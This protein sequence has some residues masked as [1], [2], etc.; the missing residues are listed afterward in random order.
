[1]NCIGAFAMLKQHKAR[2]DQAGIYKVIYSY[3]SA[4]TKQEVSPQQIQCASFQDSSVCFLT[5]FEKQEKKLGSKYYTTKNERNILQ[6]YQNS[7]ERLYAK[8]HYIV[9]SQLI[10]LHDPV[11]DISNGM[12]SELQLLKLT[13]WRPSLM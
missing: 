1:M 4:T 11:T 8:M 3:S 10:K 9:C 2:Q 6:L 13:G 7:S 12:K 5:N